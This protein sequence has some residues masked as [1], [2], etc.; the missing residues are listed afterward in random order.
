VEIYEQLQ[1]ALLEYREAGEYNPAVSLP[2]K[3]AQKT[4]CSTGYP[5]K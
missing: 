2:E 3:L 1:I 4:G 5:K